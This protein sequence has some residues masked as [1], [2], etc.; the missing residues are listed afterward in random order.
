MIVGSV[1]DISGI[2]NTLIYPI[3]EQTRDLHDDIINI[4]R[5]TVKGIEFFMKSRWE[6]DFTWMNRI[7]DTY[8][9]IWMK[10]E[11]HEEGGTAGVWVGY[12]E[13]GEKSISNYHWYD[14][15]DEAFMDAFGSHTQQLEIHH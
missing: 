12:Y 5:H 4:K 2:Y 14:L 7:L 11:W 15:C 9:S 8:Q 1:D 10:N 13:D 3:V 6:P